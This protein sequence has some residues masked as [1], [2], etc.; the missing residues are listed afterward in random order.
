MLG[1]WQYGDQSSWVYLIQNGDCSSTHC[2]VTGVT[3]FS[4]KFFYMQKPFNFLSSSET[5][6]LCS[7]QVGDPGEPNQE[8]HITFDFKDAP[9]NPHTV[10]FC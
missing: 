3:V 7:C 10:F 6:P 1:V 8:A 5:S 2:L 4:S 9:W